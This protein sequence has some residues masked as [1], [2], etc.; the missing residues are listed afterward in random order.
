MVRLNPSITLIAMKVNSSSLIISRGTRISIIIFQRN[1]NAFL[2]KRGDMRRYLLF[3]V[4]LHVS[5]GASQNSFS[6]GSSGCT[7]TENIIGIRHSMSV[8]ENEQASRDILTV[9]FELTTSPVNQIT[10]SPLIFSNVQQLSTEQAEKVNCGEKV[11]F[12]Y[13]LPQETAVINVL[14]RSLPIIPEFFESLTYE[15]AVIEHLI[16]IRDASRDVMDVSNEVIKPVAFEN[17]ESLN[18]TVDFSQGIL[19]EPDKL[20]DNYIHQAGDWKNPAPL[21]QVQSN[22]NIYKFGIFY[23]SGRTEPRDVT[24]TCLLNDQQFEAFDSSLA[25]GGILE[26]EQAIRLEGEV[27]IIEPGWH[28]LRCVPLNSIITGESDPT[29]DIILSTFIFKEE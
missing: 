4:V 16:D 18:N 27:E 24:I 11:L 14:F 29:P 15:E 17:N 26:P 8:E 2:W 28:L 9:D 5:I 23:Q 13:P 10:F 6:F 22:Q 7:K 19:L 1:L 25:W 20:R 21:A 3:L 12:T